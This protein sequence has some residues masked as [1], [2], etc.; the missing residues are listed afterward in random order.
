MKVRQDHR[1]DKSLKRQTKN[2]TLHTDVNPEIRE[3]V[4]KQFKDIRTWFLVGS[5]K[6]ALR[7]LTEILSKYIFRAVTVCELVLEKTIAIAHST[8]KT[9]QRKTRKLGF[10]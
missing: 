1:K 6:K 4:Y 7:H 3:K 9:D 10:F 2:R 5:A 8:F